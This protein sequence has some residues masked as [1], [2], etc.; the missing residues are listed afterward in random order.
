MASVVKKPKRPAVRFDNAAN[1]QEWRNT[2][3]RLLQGAELVWQPLAEGIRGGNAQGIQLTN[4]ERSRRDDYFAAFFLLA[5]HAVE[6]ELKA[7]VLERCIA[8]HGAFTDGD[9]AMKEVPRHHDLVKLAARAACRRVS[10][11]RG[12][13]RRGAWVGRSSAHA[14]GWRTWRAGIVASQ[15]STVSL[16]FRTPRPAASKIRPTGP[17]PPGEGCGSLPAHHHNSP[18]EAPCGASSVGRLVV[19]AVWSR[20]QPWGHSS[21]RHQRL[22]PSRG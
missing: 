4:A 8:K 17:R 7:L 12:T 2:G 3:R 14:V 10:C 21:R 16:R 5:G 19:C 11:S 18:Q 9:A 1:S 13:D 22:A 20:W 15:S 6:N